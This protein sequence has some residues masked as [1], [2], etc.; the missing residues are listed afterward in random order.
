MAKIE[1]P[2]LIIVN[3]L[4]DELNVSASWLAEKSGANARSLQ[5][6]VAGEYRPHDKNLYAALIKVLEDERKSRGLSTTSARM[7]LGARQVALHAFKGPKDEAVGKFLRMIEVMTPG[8]TGEVLG[9]EVNDRAM[10]PEF[11]PGDVVIVSPEL[12]LE[13]GMTVVI[14]DGR[15]EDLR[16]FQVTGSA[17]KF[18]AMRDGYTTYTG[19]EIKIKGVVVGRMR[20]MGEGHTSIDFWKLGKVE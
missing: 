9:F 11:R 15:V 4:M 12:H 17:R 5:R 2:R 7:A 3:R 20:E 6:W 1:D 13:P 16:V 19:A 14:T 8:F 18:T 10:V